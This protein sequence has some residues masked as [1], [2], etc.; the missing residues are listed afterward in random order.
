MTWLDALKQLAVAVTGMFIVLG[1]WVV[2]QG[3]VRKRS[4]CRADHDVLD[5]MAHGCGSCIRGAT[6]RNRMK[7]AG[8]NPEASPETEHNQH[9]SE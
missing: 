5:F 6:C 9:E 4:G 7:N 8:L 1:T 3:Y 2:V